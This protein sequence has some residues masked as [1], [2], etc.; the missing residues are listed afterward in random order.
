MHIFDGHC[1]TLLRCY[2]EGGGL[3]KRSGHLDLERL[4]RLGHCAQFFAVFGSK[5]DTAGDLNQVF[6]R[7][8]AIFQREMEANRDLVVHCR[9]AAEAEAAWASGRQAAFL[10][11]EGAD[12][13]DC[14]LQKLEEAYRL[15]VRAVN[16][17]WNYEN[18]LSG[19]NAEAP[20]KGLTTRGKDFVLRMQ[21]LGMLVDVSHL[22]DPGFW[23]VIELAK[24]PIFASHSNSRAVCGH[25]RNLTDAQ[26]TA[27]IGNRGVAGI[28]MAAEFL[29]DDPDLNT[30]VAHIEHWMSLGG[31]ANVSLGGD[32][33]GIDRAPRDVK[34]IRNLEDLAERLLQMNYP[35]QRVN[36]IF[37]NNLMRV[38]REVC[39][40]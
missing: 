12:L 22:S 26:F 7:E 20:E 15:G 28:N 36:D 25:K 16:L 38:V 30:V 9:T 13:L 10:S 35:E 5:T 24:K 23:D 19:S 2:L 33:D 40:M 37:Y 4:S 11:V 1:D 8:V 27:I 21:E 6:R 32:W 31:E 29:G 18:A 34:D 14:D 3:R 39:T 17:V